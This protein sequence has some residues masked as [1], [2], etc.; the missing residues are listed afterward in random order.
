MTQS[1]GTGIGARVR[2]ARIAA[3]LTQADMAGPVGRSE[4]WA[5]DVEA[6]RLPLDRYSLITVVATVCEVDVVWLIGQ[7]YC[8][9]ANRA[10]PSRTCPRS[11]LRRSSLVLSGHPGLVPSGPATDGT[12]PGWPGPGCRHQPAPP[13]REPSRGRRPP[14]RPAGGPD[15]H[16]PDVS[17]R[18]ACPSWP[19]S[20]GH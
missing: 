17:T 15:H 18:P 19:G 16:D 3:G 9:A 7:P 12:R 11:A 13:G 8:C 10:P 14:A 6:G 1:P 2:V 4:R 5:E 20:L